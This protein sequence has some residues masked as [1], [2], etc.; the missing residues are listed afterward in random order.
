M[1]PAAEPARAGAT[2]ADPPA[3]PRHVLVAAGRIGLFIL[4]TGILTALLGTAFHCLLLRLRGVGLDET[5]GAWVQLAGALAATAL[6]LRWVDRRPWRAVAMGRDEARPRLLAEGW[7]LGMLAIGLPSL[8][9]VAAGWLDF[10]P[11][12]PGEWTGAALRAT[13]LLL[14]AAVLEEVLMRGY[15][16]SWLRQAL[17]AWWAI[18]VTSVVFGLLHLGNP[19]ADARAIALVMLAGVF[20]GLVV[21][22]T[23]SVWAASAAHLAWNFTMAVLLHTAVSGLPLARPDYELRDDGPDWATGGGW[24]PEGGAAGALGML[25]GIGYL[26]WRGRRTARPAD[27]T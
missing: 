14:P 19:G 22:V 6:L 20:L 2:Q 11:A 7:V 18:G 5:L 8:L 17:G 4:V 21:V 15:V 25:A 27:P 9:L 1:T 24:G 26:S 12:A 13:A 23:R 3:R 10:A 16:F